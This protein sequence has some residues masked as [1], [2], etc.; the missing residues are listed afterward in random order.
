MMSSLSLSIRGR[1]IF[2]FSLL[3]LLL[4]VVTG[5]TIVKVAAVR[6]ATDRTVSLRVPTALTATDLVAEVYASLASLR[7]WMITGDQ[8][9]KSERIAVWRDIEQRGADMDRLA[10]HWTI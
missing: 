3:C 8:K 6:D 9:F 1:L 10:G 7:G 2:G 4:V 5:T